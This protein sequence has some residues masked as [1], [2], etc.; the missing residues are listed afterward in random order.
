[1][2]IASSLMVEQRFSVCAGMYVQRGLYQETIVILPAA[3][4]YPFK[5]HDGTAS[6]NESPK[7]HLSIKVCK[8]LP[9][10]IVRVCNVYRFVVRGKRCSQCWQNSVSSCLQLRVQ[11]YWSSQKLTNAC[12]FTEE[13]NN[14]RLFEGCC[15]VDMYKVERL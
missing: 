2:H 14:L 5:L 1:M 8:Y 6:C 10:T 11:I 7:R 13:I 3:M 4:I 15:I 12:N 9:D